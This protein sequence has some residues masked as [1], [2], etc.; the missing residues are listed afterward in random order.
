MLVSWIW[1]KSKGIFGASGGSKVSAKS[2]IRAG[3]DRPK[4]RLLAK[5]ISMRNCTEGI[6]WPNNFVKYSIY[7]IRNL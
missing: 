3:I 4:I 1:D 2:E 5:C 7:Y 6:L